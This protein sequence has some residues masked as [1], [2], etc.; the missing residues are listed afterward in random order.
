M[1]GFWI[2]H[3]KKSKLCESGVWLIKMVFTEI[4][5]FAIVVS[6][7]GFKLNM[8]SSNV[9][10]HWKISRN[11]KIEPMKIYEAKKSDFVNV[12]VVGLEFYRGT[13]CCSEEPLCHLLNQ[14]EYD[15]KH[16]GFRKWSLMWKISV[17][18]RNLDI[19]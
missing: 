13:T 9:I 1:N 4:P 18:L 12:S 3:R 15:Q 16:R 10:N 6:R 2:F 7:L 11:S 8:K 19:Y 17:E 5:L 14:F